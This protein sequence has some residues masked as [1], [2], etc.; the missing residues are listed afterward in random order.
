MDQHLV[1]DNRNKEQNS[2]VLHLP[3]GVFE[4]LDYPVISTTLKMEGTT[5]TIS[6]A[7]PDRQAVMNELKNDH[8]Q[9]VNQLAKDRMDTSHSL[10]LFDNSTVS[11][12]KVTFDC[13]SDGMALAKV[14]SSEVVVSWSKIVS[15]SKQ[16]AFVVG[17]GLDGV[18]SSISVIDCSH[19][20]SSSMVLLPLVRTSTCLPTPP[21]DS[22]STDTP[23]SDNPSPFLSVRGAGLVLSNVSLILGTG[24]LLDFGLLS[25]DSTRSD[26][27]GLGETSTFLVGSVLRN[28]TSRGCSRSGLIVAR[29]LSQKLVGTEVTL[30]TSHLCGTGCL[31]INAFGSFGCVNSSFSHCSSNDEPTSY[32]HQH[33]EQGDW[34][35]FVDTIQ[36]TLAFHLCTFT[37]MTSDYSSACVYVVAPH[38]IT[39]TECSFKDIEGDLGGALSIKGRT[40]GEGSLTLSLCS[41]LNCVGN[42]FGAAFCHDDA[43]S[44]SIGK[45]FFKNMTTTST[46]DSSIGGALAVW[47][48]ATATITN[49][50]F[51]DC[52]KPTNGAGGVGYFKDSFLRMESV[53][54][55]GNFAPLGSDIYLENSGTPA[56]VKTRVSNCNTDKPDTSVMFMKFG[57]QTGIIEQ[58]GS[59][60]TITS[61]QLNMPANVVGGTIQVKTQL[62]VKGK[63]LLLLDNAGTYDPISESSSPPAIFRVVVV[64]FPTLSKTGT[65]E[66]L[67]FGDL[68]RL[69]TNSNYSLVAAS[70][71][72]TLIDFTAPLS[73]D[74]SFNPSFV[75]RFKFEQ[76][77]TLGEV[78]VSLEGRQLPVGEYTIH[79]EG[80]PNLSLNFT[81]DDDQAGS[82]S[83]ISSTVSV[84]PGGIHTK[85]SFGET[86]KVDRITFENRPVMLRS[87]GFSLVVPPFTTP[88]IIKVN[89]TITDDGNCQDKDSVCKTLDSAF[90]TAT[91]MRMKSIELNVVLTETLSKTRSISDESEMF[92]TQG[93][94]VRPSLI[95]PDTFK[96][97]PLVVLSVSNASLSLTDV[98]A[99]IRFSSL[100]LKLVRVSSG[101][102]EFSNGV[103]KYTPHVTANSEI[104]NSNSD[105]CVWT[106]GTIE[107]VDSTAVLKSCSLTHLAQGG[108]MQRGGNVTLRDVYFES[109]GPTSRDFPSARRNVMCSSDGTLFVGGLT[110][111]GRSHLFPGSGISGDGCSVSGTATTMSIPF[112]DT[113][114]SQ[115]TRDK[116][117]GKYKLNL[118]GSGFLPC[119]L[120][121]KVFTSLE[122]ENSEESLTLAVDTSTASIFTE[123]RIEFFV[124]PQDVANL[125]KKSEWKVRLLNGDRLIASQSLVLRETPRSMLWLIPVI[126]VVLVLIA[127]VIVA[128]L[129]IWR[130]RSKKSAEKKEDK[131]A[132]T[133]EATST[134]MKETASDRPETENEADPEINVSDMP[135][136]LT[137]EGTKEASSSPEPTIEE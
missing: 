87:I 25:H 96:L 63:M 74:I 116:K 29:G 108:I 34:L 20:S 46:E 82:E 37:S 62:P 85:F 32:T 121:L 48:T 53:Q 47:R 134:E 100:D 45:C 113:Y 101:S 114:H 33:F 107:L 110:G 38:D 13:G 89:K 88:F 40:E 60:T 51:M 98:D 117:T 112:L 28:V 68:E 30:S 91:K 111:D 15:N 84:G 109:N 132:T 127:V 58:F 122:D 52:T 130:C 106:T 72:A 77:D 11:L 69:Q 75:R 115:I 97:N 78:M 17:T 71:S 3:P 35:Y 36:I 49:T 42:N 90:E 124:T 120:Q 94:L 99:L 1:R 59:A 92:M 61:L 136:E 125:S 4:L 44:L 104:G 8:S 102:F 66:V 21:R 27:I 128:L 55:R 6:H 65:S 86:Y 23:L 79:F 10:F 131:I 118:V 135:T 67:S 133:N 103:I 105:L 14:L 54:F 22:S 7:Y 39:M 119:G 137:E 56:E 129:L 73:I 12:S 50:V 24:P 126:V 2:D 64:D 26:E 41:F 19:V 18:G 43:T 31:D 16:T 123:T 5:S 80:N 83:Q 70:I 76:T 81:F 57:V 95:V 93:G 9:H